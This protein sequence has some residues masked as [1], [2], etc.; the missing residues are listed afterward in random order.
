MKKS[1]LLLGTA[2]ALLAASGAQA[3]TLYVSNLQ[4]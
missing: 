2:I 3:G 4:Y 1:K